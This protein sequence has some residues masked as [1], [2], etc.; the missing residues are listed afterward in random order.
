M[1]KLLTKHGQ[2]AAFAIGTLISLAFVAMV[3]GS[4]ADMSAVSD[5]SLNEPGLGLGLNASIGLTLICVAAIIAFGLYQ[6]ATD[7]KVRCK[8]YRRFK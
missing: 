1:Y 2:L 4:D 6:V 7:L 5:G 3:S 8:F